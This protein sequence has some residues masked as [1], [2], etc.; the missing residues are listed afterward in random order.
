MIYNLKAPGYLNAGAF[1]INVP[2]S[3]VPV[4]K[5]SYPLS[6]IQQ[7]ILQVHVFSFY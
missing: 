4:G 3:R 6:K 7:E 1:Y 2:D 5:R